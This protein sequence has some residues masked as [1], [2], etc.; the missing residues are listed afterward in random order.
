VRSCR[1]TDQYIQV[2][3]LRFPI[4]KMNG[5][6]ASKC[7]QNLGSLK[8]TIGYKDLVRSPRTKSIGGRLWNGE[9]LAHLHSRCPVAEPKTKYAHFT[10][11]SPSAKP[12]QAEVLTKRSLRAPE[13]LANNAAE[14]NL[15]P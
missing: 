6:S 7:G 9:S 5:A 10:S 2:T 3:E 14:S 8:R 12:V 1:G 13:S 15:V 4:I 11:M